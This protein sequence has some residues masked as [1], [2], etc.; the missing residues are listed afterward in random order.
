MGFN[1][2]VILKGNIMKTP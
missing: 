1:I 2:F